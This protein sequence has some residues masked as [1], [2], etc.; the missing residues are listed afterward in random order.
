MFSFCSSTKRSKGRSGNTSFHNFSEAFPKK[1]PKSTTTSITSKLCHSA[2]ARHALRDSTRTHSGAPSVQTARQVSSRDAVDREGAWAQARVACGTAT[3]VQSK[4]ERGR[5]CLMTMLSQM[6]TW[7]GRHLL[8]RGRGYLLPVLPSRTRTR[9]GYFFQ[10]ER[11]GRFE[12]QPFEDAGGSECRGGGCARARLRAA[13]AS[14]CLRG[15]RERPKSGVAVG[16]W[17]RL[18]LRRGVRVGLRR[19]RP[20][21]F[22]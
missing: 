22:V 12:E 5:P 18:R 14:G 16:E 10:P 19:G 9:L 1:T 20:C 11:E 15:V 7:A 13:Y 6:L 17:V 3:R 8:R 4:A 2:I 21:C